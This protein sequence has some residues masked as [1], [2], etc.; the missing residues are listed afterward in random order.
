MK[1]AP[2]AFARYC[3]SR[4]G[5][6]SPSDSSFAST[7]MSVPSVM[8]AVRSPLIPPSPPEGERAEG[9]EKREG[10]PFLRG[11]PGG[12]ELEPLLGRVD[13]AFDLR[14]EHD[15]VQ[16][17]ADGEERGVLLHDD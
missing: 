2:E 6:R 11:D 1:R 16:V 4:S 8:A 12:P 9:E 7:F 14:A 15:Q 13:E 5:S 10:L 17:V 3:W